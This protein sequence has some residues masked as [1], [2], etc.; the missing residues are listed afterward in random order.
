VLADAR[1]R[2]TDPAAEKQAKRKAET[3]AEL[4]DLY[5]ADAEAGRLLTRRKVPKKASTL[6]SDKG[7]L[8]KHVKPLLGK[9]K[10]AAVTSTDV[11]GFMH[12][13]AEGKTAAR[14]KTG[15]KRGLSNV[16]GGTGTASRTIG[17]LGA[18]FAYGVKRGMRADNPVHGV[19]RFADQ[20]RRL[21]EAEYAALGTA[22]NDATMEN[23]W[24][25][26][27]AAIRFLALHADHTVLEPDAVAA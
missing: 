15:K 27:L 20:K 12:A 7:R 5:W 23:M 1:I 22:L 17:L 13:V 4:V 2:G 21:S 19:T 26:A 24:P 18:V 10:V 16:R 25:P 11:E 6:R 9:L 3:V 8:E 14:T